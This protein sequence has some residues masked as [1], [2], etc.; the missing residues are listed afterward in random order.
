M[1]MRLPSER[2]MV[3]GTGALMGLAGVLLARAGNPAN[4]GICISCFFENLSGALGLT[5]AARFSYFRPELAG[6]AGG[7][8]LSAL[9]AR[10][11]RPRTGRFPLLLFALGLLLIVGSSV[12]MGCPIKLVLR[13]AA[14]DLTSLAGAAGLAAGIWTGVRY[15]RAG[16]DLGSESPQP[17]GVMQGMAFP[18]G[19]PLLFALAL[20]VPGLLVAGASGP[21]ALRAPLPLALGAGLAL[22]AMGQLSRFCVTGAFTNF[23]LASD[24]ML[25]AGLGAFFAVALGAGLALGLFHPGLYDQP[26]SNPDHLWN[27][28]GMALVG[29]AAVL[30]GGCPFRQ[31]VLAGEGR[32]DAALAALGMLA[33][34]ALVQRWGIAS[35]SAGPTGAGKLAVLAGLFFCFAVARLHRRPL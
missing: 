20:A 8:L 19:L 28:L 6:I 15:V 16:L 26:G 22:G 5:G 29:F 31:L 14:G 32:V 25:L 13:L 12:F 9:A 23:F 35:T 24:R 33:G 21:A 4:S 27:F 30:A 10:E 18:A 7:A 34:G 11:F 3:L 2:A 17:A 1:R